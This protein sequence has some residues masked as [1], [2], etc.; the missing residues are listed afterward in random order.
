MSE[1]YRKPAAGGAGRLAEKPLGDY[2]AVVLRDADFSLLK[3]GVAGG[4]GGGGSF[5][6]PEMGS[7]CACCNADASTAVPFD[8]STDRL[9]VDPIQVPTCATCAGHLRKNTNAEQLVGGS[10]IPIAIGLGIWSVMNEIYALTAVAV[11]VGIGVT[12]WILQ[13]G[14][15]RRETAR[16]GH[17]PHL[18]IMVAIGQCA[19]R[20]TNKRLA[21]E[22][23]QNHAKVLHRAR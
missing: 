13:K 2:Y 12:R 15:K 17:H 22:L 20:T 10:L 5:P 7:L 23:V 6:V 9:R 11:V 8:A 16:L 14:R 1:P 19:V 3:V 21:E 4:L 18:E